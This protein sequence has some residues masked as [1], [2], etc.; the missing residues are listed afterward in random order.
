MHRFAKL[1]IALFP[2]AT[3]CVTDPVDTA[4]TEQ[5]ATETAIPEAPMDKLC[6]GAW[7]AYGACADQAELD[8]EVDLDDCLAATCDTA[9][10]PAYC[11]RVA[12]TGQIDEACMVEG[13][14]QVKQSVYCVWRSS[15]TCQWSSACEV[16]LC[17]PDCAVHQGRSNGTA[18]WQE[19]YDAYGGYLW[20]QNWSFS[21]SGSCCYG[22]PAWW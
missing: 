10:P 9:D 7:E 17:T 18:S 3:A 8:G 20:S 4:S 1:A 19:C 6:V 2:F 15:F 22:K 13:P 14:D 21:P 5:D 11:A 12:D 16:V